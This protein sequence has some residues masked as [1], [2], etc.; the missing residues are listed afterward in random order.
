MTQG[1][2]PDLL[3]KELIT[4]PAIF[5][6]YRASIHAPSAI[7]TTPPASLLTTA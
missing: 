2:K 7:R 5:L 1:G 4:R 3:R 6:S